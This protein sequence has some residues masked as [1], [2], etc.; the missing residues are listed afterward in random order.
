MTTYAVIDF[1][2]TG[3]S[4]GL[5][6]R[7]TEIAVVLVRDGQLVDRYQS[8]M[9]PGQPI[10]WQIQQLTGITDAMVRQAPPVETVMAEASAFVGNHVP[11]AH[12]AAFDRKFW[13]CELAALGRSAGRAFLCSLM[14]SRR[15]FPSATSHKLASLV[16]GLGLPATGRYHRALADAEATAYLLLKIQETIAERFSVPHVTA[17]L[18]TEVQQAPVKGLAQTVSRYLARQA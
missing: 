3:A 14:L 12:N 7:P 10:P 11:V 17:D 8:L 9:N 6:A 15:V 16:S 4:P 2:T 5:N 18:L 13:E 1:E